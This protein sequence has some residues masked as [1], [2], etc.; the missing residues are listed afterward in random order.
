M[1]ADE[2]KY[3]GSGGVIL[4]MNS[5]VRNHLDI[6]SGTWPVSTDICS[7]KDQ[8][9]AIAVVMRNRNNFSRMLCKHVDNVLFQFFLIIFNLERIVSLS[10]DD[11][12]ASVSLAVQCICSYR[13]ILQIEF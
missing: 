11:D 6:G 5:L 10:P 4:L 3:C 13:A 1:I 9:F 12:R 8:N 2:T 7:E